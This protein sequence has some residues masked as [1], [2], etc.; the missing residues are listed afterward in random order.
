MKLLDFTHTLTEDIPVYPGTETPVFQE[1]TTLERDGFREKKLTFY[2]HTGTHLDAPAHILPEG[3][4]LDSLNPDAFFG[5]ALVLDFRGIKEKE[6]VLEDLLL[7]EEK[8][9]TADFLLFRTGWQRY[10]GKD[11]YF[12]DYP[13]LSL[14]TAQWLSA[15][16]LKG[17]GVDAIS[18][19]KPD[20]SGFEV[21]T[22]FLEKGTLLIENLKFPEN[23]PE[24][25]FLFSCFPLKIADADGSPIRA[26]GF[27]EPK[28]R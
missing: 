18:V 6:I 13:V 2:S 24:A 21:H 14:E 12:R 25:S 17:M 7:M 8:I 27:W 22:C 28:G 15:F 11:E 23:T 26:V 19:D 16:H 4:T 9:Q 10:W 1:A 3:A 5:K 20:S